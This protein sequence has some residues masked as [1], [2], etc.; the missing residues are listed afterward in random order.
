MTTISPEQ[1]QTVT[2]EPTVADAIDALVARAQV[3]LKEYDTFTQ[4]DVNLLGMNFLS[5]LNGWRVEGNYLVL[6]P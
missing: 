5:S 6:Q 1:A 4:D 2:T 3:A